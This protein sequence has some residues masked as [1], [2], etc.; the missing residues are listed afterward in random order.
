MNSYL[1]SEMTYKNLTK[2]NYYVVFKKII[3]SP[4]F[5]D[6]KSLLKYNTNYHNNLFDSLISENY[7]ENFKL[8]KELKSRNKLKLFIKII[9]TKYMG[10]LI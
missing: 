6:A 10:W 2:N 5:K 4:Q 1:Y 8:M 9:L 3:D 7:E